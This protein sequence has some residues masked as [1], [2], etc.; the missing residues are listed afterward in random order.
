VTARKR[1]A[2][3]QTELLDALL[4]G[5]E[6][7]PGFDVDRVHIEAHL[8]RA[9][10]RRVVAGIRPDLPEAL[11]DRF[12]E[13]FD[14]Y[15]EGRPKSVDTRAREDADAFGAWLIERGELKKTRRWLPHRRVAAR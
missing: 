6:P 7:P 5:G 10:R 14:A 13:L 12:Q 9:K 4:A 15:A 1:L 11:G 2:E 3:Q 8:L